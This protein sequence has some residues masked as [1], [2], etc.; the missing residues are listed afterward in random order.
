ML[1]GVLGEWDEAV[2]D[3]EAG[4]ERHRDMGARPWLALSQIELARVLEARGDAAEAARAASLRGDAVAAA[5][6]L[7]L[8]AV[9]W[10]AGQP[11]T[12]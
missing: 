7:G 10:R 4:L 9:R 12:G 5:D 3:L 8:G 6:E 11:V 2:V 1:S